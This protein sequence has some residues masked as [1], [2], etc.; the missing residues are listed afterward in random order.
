VWR[1]T[2]TKLGREVAVKLLPDAFAQVADRLA[3]FTHEAQVLA[4]LNHPGIA[5][6]YEV[7]ERAL[8]MELVEGPTLEARITQGPVPL[9]EA[10]EIARQVAEALE[11]AHERGVVHRDL[12]P[13]NIKLTLDGRVKVLDFGLA[14]A[15]GNDSG[16]GATVTAA[17]IVGVVLGTPAYMA[18][19][20][21][22]G[23]PADRRV[24]IWAFGVVL[25]EMLTGRRPGLDW[26]G[27]PPEMPAAVRRL[28]RLCLNRDPRQRLQSIGDARVLIEEVLAGRDVEDAATAVD[29]GPRGVRAWLPWA[30]AAAG[31]VAAGVLGWMRLHEQPE[32]G[33][34]ARFDVAIPKT[35]VLL[36]PRM[37]PDGS[38]AL[39]YV[40]DEMG[41]HLK[42]YDLPTGELRSVPGMEGA[43]TA[44]WS[45]DSRYLA[46]SRSTG[47]QRVELASGS[48]VLLANVKAWRS[49]WSPKG[50]IVYVDEPGDIWRIGAD[51]GEP[52]VLLRHPAGGAPYIPVDFLP[53]GEHFLFYAGL[54]GSQTYETRIGSLGGGTSALP[55]RA[56]SFVQYAA[57]GYLLFVR[58]STLLAQPCDPKTLKPG[59]SPTPLAVVGAPNDSRDFSASNNG[60]LGFH[61]GGDYTTRTMTWFDRSGRA[62]G[63]VGDPDTYTNPALSPDGNLLAVGIGDQG[64]G[65]RDIW[66]FDLP[67]GTKSRLTFDPGDDLNPV[68]SPDGR[69]IAFSSG[70]RGHRDLYR[71]LA[72]GT[73]AEELLAESATNK[74]AEDWS[75]DGRYLFFNY[76][77]AAGNSDIYFYSFSDRTSQRYLA[78][79][80]AE[81]QAHLSPDGHWLAYRSNESGTIQIY[82]QPFPATGG[83]WQVSTTVGSDPQ[84]R[85]DGKEL[86]YIAGQSLMAVD[87]QPAGDS[88]RIRVPHKL[89]D[90]RVAP[91]TTRNRYVATSDGQRFLVLAPKDEAAAPPAFTVLMNW[92]GLLPG[93]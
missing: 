51:G 59:G 44:S 19:E 85:A 60:V 20:Q 52:Q 25:I 1:A 42:V 23:R 89:F 88:P 22:Q 87:V 57:P 37:S 21:A 54:I 41:S 16:D 45:P 67:R 3:R 62:L 39:I 73:G 53:D 77:V 50:V 48:S 36:G 74:A 72:S 58:G 61:S 34:V 84:W 28:A 30:A 49:A 69:Y 2:D 92:Q 7:E 65:Q 4:S 79:P 63:T 70:R 38:K 90:T 64:A 76:A 68:W 31:I 71:K 10:L 46:V 75:R 9:E 27:L 80:L 18:P 43:S 86:Y 33:A 82:I 47:L 26:S 83:K 78:T 93:K 6:I 15:A 8:I 13:S 35:T 66:V 24:D 55:V 11:Y 29:K 17:T 32:R 91:G 5:A 14:K 12:K 81:E 56:D 40:R